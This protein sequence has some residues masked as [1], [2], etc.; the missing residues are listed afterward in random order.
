M[1]SRKDQLP[2]KRK[3]L[4]SGSSEVCRAL[5]LSAPSGRRKDSNHCMAGIL[6]LQPKTWDLQKTSAAAQHVAHSAHCEIERTVT[7]LRL[8]LCLPGR[9]PGLAWPDLSPRAD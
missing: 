2:A 3:K 8:Q 6:A 4:D 1:M 7:G 5:V 9:A